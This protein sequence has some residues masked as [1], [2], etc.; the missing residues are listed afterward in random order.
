MQ[1]FADHHTSPLPSRPG[2]LARFARSR[3]KKALRLPLGAF[4]LSLVLGAA[5][6]LPAAPPQLDAIFPAGAQRGTRIEVTLVGKFDPWPC[7]LHFPAE[8]ISFEP[9]PEK[10]GAGT[11]ELSEDLPLGPLHAR[12][13][14][15][16]GA[17]APVLFVV[18]EHPE[19]RENNESAS[20]IA[21]APSLD[22]E[23]L[24]LVVNGRLS[25]A[26][27]MDGFRFAL[28]EGDTLRMALE[29]YALRSPVDPVL[30]VYD[31]AGN[32]LLLQHNGPHNLDPRATFT[33]PESGEYVVAVAGFAHPPATNIAFVGSARTLYRLHL[34][35]EPEGLPERLRPLDPGPEAPLESTE[36]TEE[37]PEEAAAAS[38]E[39]ASLAEG[40]DAVSAED[41]PDPLLRRIRPGQ[42]VGATLLAQGEEHRYRIAAQRGDALLVRVDAR[43]LGHPVDPVLRIVRP[44]GADL[45]TVDDGTAPSLDPEF[46]WKVA[47]DGDF[48]L[49]VWD[50]FHRGGPEMRYRLLV[51]PALPAFEALVD[52]HAC[53]L[54]PG[55]KEEL[56]VTLKRLYEHSAPVVATVEGLPKG[57][58]LKQP[59]SYPEKDGEFTL[60][61]EA[62]EDSPAFNGPIAIRVSDAPPAPSESEDEEDATPAAEEPVAAD[63]PP[64][65]ET[66]AHHSFRNDDYRGPFL[67]DEV[68]EIWLTVPPLEKPETEKDEAK[69]GEEKEP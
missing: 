60:V 41:A 14:N 6:S 1:L 22:G 17:S 51:E 31:A 13:Y 46:F 12:A 30:K 64:P 25:A 29:A 4:V 50:R 38:A 45:R 34:A 40:A 32:R 7:E 5:T 42:A 2:P 18:G 62:A 33:A 44:G 21:K 20:T 54:K 48:T 27:E 19:I 49:V 15:E 43:S 68:A 36:S 58:T 65:F 3:A 39:P 37:D 56:K 10:A 55:E 9:D 69:A 23:S 67:I 47:E 11:L 28:G 61:L 57:V 52:R 63:P 59:E 24:P 8:G 66:L 35:R 53:V 26:H 16:E